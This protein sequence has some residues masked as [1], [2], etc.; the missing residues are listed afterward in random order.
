M[1]LIGGIFSA[2]STSKMTSKFAL[3]LLSSAIVSL[4]A[5]EVEV[6]ISQ[7]RLRGSVL[8]SRNGS[9]FYAFRSIPYAK[10]PIGELRFEVSTCTKNVFI[11]K[12]GIVI[13][14][15]LVPVT[16]TC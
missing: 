13:D 14:V 11:D 9:K 8:Q 2:I 6:S 1:E 12:N 3:I 15:Y 4:A 16:S 5:S 10:P 7:G